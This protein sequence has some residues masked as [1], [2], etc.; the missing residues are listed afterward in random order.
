MCADGG[1][2]EAL[3]CVLPPLTHYVGALPKGES[4]GT[5]RR[6]PLRR[7]MGFVRGRKLPRQAPSVPIRRAGRRARDEVWVMLYALGGE[8]SLIGGVEIPLWHPHL[9]RRFLREVRSPFFFV[10]NWSGRA[11]NLQGCLLLL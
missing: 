4:F 3:W 8:K 10:G 5:P 6:R 1:A 9:N 7:G 2:V 11:V